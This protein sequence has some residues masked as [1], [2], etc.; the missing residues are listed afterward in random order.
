MS[1]VAGRPSGARLREETMMTRWARSS[2]LAFL[3]LV[4]VAMVV[5]FAGPATSAKDVVIGIVLPLSGP[6]A[7]N[8]QHGLWGAQLA[9][10]Q[11]NAAGGIK[12]LGGARLKLQISDFGTAGVGEA[13]N[14]TQRL[15]QSYHPVAICGLWASPATLAAS[16]VTERAKVPL[17]TQS[18]ADQIT[19]RDYQY[20]F[21]LPAKQAPM[22][23]QA[24]DA[25][26]ELAK[27]ANYPIRTI[28]TIA[29][30]TSSGK[31]GAQASDARFKARGVSVGAEYFYPAGLTSATSIVLKVLSVK[32]DLIF[33]TGG[34]PD[35]ALLQKTFYEQGYRGPYLGGGGGF[36]TTQ[37]GEVL[38]PKISSGAFGSAGWNW[39][40]PGP[41][42]KTLFKEFTEK[43]KVP[44]PAQEAGEDYAII[45][46]IKEALEAAKSD[47]PQAVRDAISKLDITS[48]PATVMPGGHVAFDANGMNKHVLPIVVQWQD[49]L[50]RTVYPR[51]I[52]S[53]KAKFSF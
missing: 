32:P 2:V 40:M 28:A 52:A 5:T 6:Y 35:V 4:C 26:L 3:G 50:P 19:E 44:F 15:I 43:Y 20:V 22:S 13:A 21:Q 37:Y 31:I 24:T 11:I 49:G 16:T 33:T 25:V 34:L 23:Q 17:L 9:V 7:L 27:A 39:D 14:I 36:V 29:D 38:G 42:A 12:A 8:G 1:E 51:E 10:D 48:G 53:A 47:N 18:F 30:D 45:Y 41:A 46:I